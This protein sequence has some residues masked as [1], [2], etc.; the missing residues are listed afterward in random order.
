ML[1][2]S[3][4]NITSGSFVTTTIFNYAVIV[5]LSEKH[6]FSNII[7]VLITMFGVHQRLCDYALYNLLLT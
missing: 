2:H 1:C 6:C 7:F 3:I 5:T 4:I